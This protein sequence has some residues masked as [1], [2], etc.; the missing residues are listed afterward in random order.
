MAKGAKKRKYSKG[1]NLVKLPFFS[2]F[3]NKQALQDYIHKM[4]L[5]KRNSEI[6]RRRSSVLNL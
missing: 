2:L 3:T 1:E 5:T 4:M 6:A